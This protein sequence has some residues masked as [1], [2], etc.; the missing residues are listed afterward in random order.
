MG[1]GI[2]VRK[3]GRAARL[4]EDGNVVAHAGGCCVGDDRQDLDVKRTVHDVGD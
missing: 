4:I 3:E 2:G 1:Q